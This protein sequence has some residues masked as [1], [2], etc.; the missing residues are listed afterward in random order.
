MFKE[1]SNADHSRIFK[2]AI[3][4]ALILAAMG[5]TIYSQSAGP[6]KGSGKPAEPAKSTAKPEDQIAAAW[7]KFYQGSLPEAE[8]LLEPLVKS[9]TEAIRVEATYLLGRC[10]LAAGLASE[11]ATDDARALAE[12][13]KTWSSISSTLNSYIRRQKIEQA[14]ELSMKESGLA[15]A[16]QILEDLLKEGHASTL[17]PEA[18]IEL[19]R[20][21]IA[22]SDEAGAIK[23]LEFAIAF[24]A[25][26]SQG[27]EI[28]KESVSPFIAAAKDLRANMDP[29]KVLFD[30]SDRLRVQK[31]Y[32]DA[33]KGFSQVVEKFP[34]SEYSHRAG[35]AIGLT[36]LESGQ[37]AS[38]C[39]H[40][41]KFISAASSGPWRGQAFLQLLDLNLAD[42][43]I[44]EAA[45]YSTLAQ[46]A[47]NS[48][49]ADEKSKPS[50]VPVALPIALRVGIIAY[51]RKD[52]AGA[53]EAFDQAKAML[54]KGGS[55]EQIED[56]DRL[57]GYCKNGTDVIP[58]ECRTGS[59]DQKVATALG[60]G[61]IF[62]LCRQ[63]EPAEKIFT[64]II[65]EPAKSTSGS[66]GTSGG[67]SGNSAS[68]AKLGNP[69]TEQLA[70]ARFGRAVA[71]QGRNNNEAK[72]DLQESLKLVPAG[73]GSWQD[74]TLYCLATLLQNE[75]QAKLDR[76]NKKDSDGS[77]KS[78][79]PA[80][81][82]SAE[83]VKKL[84][85]EG[86]AHAEQR[87]KALAEIAPLWQD[88]IDKHPQSLRI[89][90]A[91]YYC[92]LAIVAKAD[93]MS[94]SAAQ[95][96]LYAQAVETLGKLTDKYSTSPY[97]GDSYVH[98]IDISLERLFDMK[99]AKDLS[100]R[101]SVWAK[102]S[103]DSHK[104]SANP[105][106]L[107]PW[108]ISRTL[109]DNMLKQAR[110]D[111]F[112][113]VTI[114]AY[115]SGDYDRAMEML[116][117]AGPVPPPQQFTENVDTA[118]VGLYYLGAAIRSKKPL[119][120]KVALDAAKTDKEKLAIQ[121]GDLYLETIRPNHAEQIFLRLAENDPAL[122][123]VSPEIKGYA[124]L[125]LAGAL[126]RQSDKRPQA[127]EWLKKLQSDEYKGTY[128]GG[129]GLFRLAVFTYNQTQDAKGS[130]P[131]YEEMLA[132]YPDHPKAEQAYAY[133]CFNVVQA[134]DLTKAKKV[135]EAFINK[136][137]QSE[138]LSSIKELLSSEIE[139][140]DVK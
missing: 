134:G 95:T 84:I 114:V 104:I 81:P 108:A 74:E 30:K 35:Y 28:S 102:D 120:N 56:I 55:K 42:L 21:C 77:S 78:G 110:S 45:K 46:S 86:K 98:Q 3:T 22:Q 23:A 53:A 131:L 113:R 125:Q 17:V 121:L 36:L 70:F 94:D 100:D 129:Y 85:A 64:R 93:E 133:Y 79:Q 101:C 16:R 11:D 96:K 24:A 99:L 37:Q 126:D 112:F 54:G 89:E 41:S 7:A 48:A 105:Q 32:A 92:G 34:T 52:T 106:T 40:W 135:A 68:T 87:N 9:P 63:Y 31:K 12:A 59:A 140:G 124:I 117:S 62:N 10:K 109:P 69:S 91:L 132:K 43:N 75:A 103:D 4:A 5:G 25:K 33:I 51:A 44:E 61:V 123:K 71:L 76:E 57:I 107:Q 138:W 2:Q 137:P 13:K 73:K 39:E 29:A 15:Q 88:I 67:S 118:R 115:F 38:A 58:S 139:K 122:E 90:P 50:W 47:I 26:L 80:K 82:P 66:S 60:L 18:A 130:L 65:G 8:K 49:L 27:G 20:C 127:L 116:D 128:W 136:Y 119:T 83:D 14:L 72:A 19:A 6:N 111:C 1:K 97:A